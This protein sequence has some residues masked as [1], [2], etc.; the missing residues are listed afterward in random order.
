MG[1]LCIFVLD[2]FYLEYSGTRVL[3]EKFIEYSSIWMSSSL[4]SLDVCC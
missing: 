3:E 1:D 2:F 4:E